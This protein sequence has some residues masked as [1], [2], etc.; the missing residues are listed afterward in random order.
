MPRCQPESIFHNIQDSM[1]SLEPRNH[2]RTGP[3]YSTIVTDEEIDPKIA[4]MEM[5]EE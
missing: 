3:E 5:I 4:C 2:T 1:F